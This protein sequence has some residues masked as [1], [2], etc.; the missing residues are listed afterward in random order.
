[1]ESNNLTGSIPAELGNLPGL[2]D[3]RL[4][5][6]ELTGSIPAELGNLTA[7]SILNLFD[8]SLTGAIPAEL[9]SLAALR[10]LWLL[11]NSLTGSIPA[12]TRK[13]LRP[14]YAPTRFERVE[15]ELC[16]SRPPFWVEN[17]NRL[18][19][20]DAT[21]SPTQVCPMPDSQGLHGC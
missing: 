11:E 17:S 1:M 21:L 5:S 20:V 7:L 12:E 8:N 15:W 14:H 10:I 2:N 3:L 4:N 19:P 18:I 6:N 9:G 16:H 13:P